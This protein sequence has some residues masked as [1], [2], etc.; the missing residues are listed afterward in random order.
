MQFFPQFW[1][2]VIIYGNSTVLLNI[3]HTAGRKV[4]FQNEI[5]AFWI[6]SEQDRLGFLVVEHLQHLLNGDDMD[7]RIVQDRK[8]K[9][10]FS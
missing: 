5:A 2:I 6:E 4:P 10:S 3:Y 1:S 8:R 7:N 9:F